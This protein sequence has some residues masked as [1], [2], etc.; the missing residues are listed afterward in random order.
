MLKY[1]K[2]CGEKLR[3]Q[4]ISTGTCKECEAAVSRLV[5]Q[6]KVRGLYPRKARLRMN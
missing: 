4:D 6:K 3:Q 2:I 1:C 5:I